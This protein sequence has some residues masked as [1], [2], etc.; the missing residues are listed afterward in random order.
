MTLELKQI[1]RE[2]VNDGE[3]KTNKDELYDKLTQDLSNINPRKILLL[4]DINART[5]K[6]EKSMVNI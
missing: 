5:E 1:N 6:F 4:R 2:I 3:I